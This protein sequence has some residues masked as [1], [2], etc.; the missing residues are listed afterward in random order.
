MSD[1]QRR[2]SDG[3]PYSAIIFDM[4]GLMLD[5]EMIERQVWQRAT[6]KLKCSMGDEDFAL[7]VG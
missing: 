2:L 6:Q 1:Y 3:R 7:L 4:D 5:T